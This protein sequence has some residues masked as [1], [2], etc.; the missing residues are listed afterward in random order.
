MKNEDARIMN[1]E[2]SNEDVRFMYD[3]IVG[4]GTVFLHFLPS[5]FFI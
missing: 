5:S 1:E 2:F 4:L 3:G